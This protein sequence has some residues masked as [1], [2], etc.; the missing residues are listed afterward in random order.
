V[1]CISEGLYPWG[2]VI[3]EAVV[4]RFPQHFRTMKMYTLIHVVISLV[5][6]FSGFVVLFGMLGGKRLNGWTA[7]FLATTV[8][9]SATGFGFPFEKVT[10]AHI[11]GVISLALLALALYAR[12][13]RGM[14]G[15][16]RKTY[17][18]TAM[19]GQYLNVFVL[20]VQSFQKIPALKDLAPTQTETPFKVAQLVVLVMFIVLIF[21]AVVRFREK[22]QP[23]S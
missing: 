9:T 16:W 20:V 1:Q 3:Q 18:I 17:V 5:G 11:V 19:I 7:L 12:Y 10:P 14:C 22:P 13:V 21:L 23:A 8:A 15:G 6:I 4:V 2:Q